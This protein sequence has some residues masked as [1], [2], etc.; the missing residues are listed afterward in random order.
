MNWETI[1][2]DFIVKYSNQIR[3]AA[4]PVCD[5]LEITYFTYHRIDL[6]GKYTVLV[7]RPDW[8]ERYVEKKLY[9][10]D[11]YLR[12]PDRY[13]PGICGMLCNGGKEYSNQILREGNEIMGVGDSLMMIEKTEGYV[14]FFGFV[15]KIGSRKLSD[16]SNNR[17]AYLKAF[18][19]YFKRE[20]K[21]I[22]QLMEEGAS[23][24]ID[25]KGDD[26]YNPEPIQTDPSKELKSF[27]KEIGLHDLVRFAESLSRQEK[28]CLFCL[29]DGKT[30]KETAAFLSLSPRT[31]ESYL[32]HIK[33]K[34]GIYS[35]ELFDISKELK[36]FGLLP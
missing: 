7:N 34:N 13:Q 2:Q 18:A 22:I 9:L 30:A 33:N 31:V 36:E 20:T 17:P 12:H 29:A 16:T 21:S 6:E 19:K 35:S 26:F 8:A 4:Q 1:V 28:K 15:S 23:P 27:L 11:P 25:L 10:K 24:L 3:K 32:E 5:H 14:E